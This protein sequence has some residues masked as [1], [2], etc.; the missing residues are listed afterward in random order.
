MLYGSYEHGRVGSWLAKTCHWLTS[1][2][3]RVWGLE[4]FVLDV[5][6]V[7]AARNLALM[8][9]QQAECDF[10]CMVDHDTLPDC[11]PGAPPFFEV[12]FDYLYDALVHDR[13]PAWIAAPIQAVNGQVCCHKRRIDPDGAQH[14]LL[15]EA[16]E[17]YG[18]SG[19]RPVEGS[20]A[21][22]VVLDL[23]VLA[24]MEQPWFS[25]TY[26]DA[27][28]THLHAGEDITFTA[29]MTEQMGLPVLCAW[30]CWAGHDKRVQLGKPRAT[31]PKKKLF[32][33]GG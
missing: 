14:L 30:D 16:S 5:A 32:L 18:L 33:S 2:R 29:R 23:R 22:L 10:L 11:E 15:M 24:S 26:K 25:N 28:C 4:E 8:T 27:N 21:G 7:Y 19:I 20:G 9:A 17:T 13:P 12:A 1:Q 3:E 6:P 31:M